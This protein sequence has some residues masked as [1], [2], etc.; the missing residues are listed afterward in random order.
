MN[1]KDLDLGQEVEFLNKVGNS[2]EVATG[3]LTGFTL[4][5]EGYVCVM[6]E[7]EG[8]VKH[9]EITKLN[10]SKE[11]E[12]K[13][14]EFDTMVEGFQKEI[15]EKLADRANEL[16]ALVKESKDKLFK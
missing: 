13:L 2:Y 8:E 4:S 5:A 1:Y 3:K 15:D 12:G 11:F 16:K 9:A 14:V 6:V 10:T 7:V